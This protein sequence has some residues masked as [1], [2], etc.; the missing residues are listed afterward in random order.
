[1]PK[2]KPKTYWAGFIDG[3]FDD[4]RPGWFVSMDL[5]KDVELLGLF[6]SKREAKRLYTDVRRVKIVE[7]KGK[8]R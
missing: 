5:V 3:Q 8:K 6:P 1:M 4:N 7:V 2:K